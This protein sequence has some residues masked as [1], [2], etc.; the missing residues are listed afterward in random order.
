MGAHPNPDQILGYFEI[1]IGKWTI[2]RWGGD[3]G[4]PGQDIGYF[5]I[6]AEGKK[7][8]SKNET[9]KEIDEGL[10]PIRTIID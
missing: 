8:H 6:R 10:R 1:I 7:D 3:Q 4:H 9:H 2:S 5:E